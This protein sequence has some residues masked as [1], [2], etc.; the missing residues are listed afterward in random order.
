MSKKSLITVIMTNKLFVLYETGIRNLDIVD[1]GLICITEY[2][3][4][5][6]H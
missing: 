3:K 5:K 4:Y 6:L 1:T 2:Y